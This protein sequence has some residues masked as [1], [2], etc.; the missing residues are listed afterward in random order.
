MQFSLRTLLIVTLLAGPGVGLIWR[1]VAIEQSKLD[2]QWLKSTEAQQAA[3]QTEQR[4][5]MEQD[6]HWKWSQQKGPP[7]LPAEFLNEGTSP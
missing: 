6:W 4:R 1:A 3:A 7:V 2:A 5:L